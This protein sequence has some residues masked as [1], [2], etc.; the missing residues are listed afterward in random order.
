M[1]HF[2]IVAF[3]KFDLGLCAEIRWRTFLVAINHNK[4][5]MKKLKVL[6]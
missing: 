2:A 4:I 3:D 6:R 5:R 1:Y